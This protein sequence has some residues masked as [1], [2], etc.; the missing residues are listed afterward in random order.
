M[1]DVLTVAVV[2][3][4][5]LNERPAVP[6]GSRV[7]NHAGVPSSRDTDSHLYVVRISSGPSVDAGI[8]RRP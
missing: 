5:N 2:V 6:A 7:E 1:I 3:D 8:I 4:M